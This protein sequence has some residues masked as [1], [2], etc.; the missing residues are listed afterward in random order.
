MTTSTTTPGVYLVQ[1]PGG[2]YKI[3]ESKCPADRL[4]TLDP[5]GFGFELLHAIPSTDRKGLESIL[6][7]AFA[8]RRVRGE[9]FRLAEEDVALIRSVPAAELLADLPAAVVALH[10]A[11]SPQQEDDTSTPR[12]ERPDP[13]RDIVVART[14]ELGLTAYAVAKACGIDPDTVR[15]YL[16]GR[17]SLNSR[18]LS[19]ILMSLGWDAELVWSDDENAPENS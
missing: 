16:T 14:K 12:T 7:T 2:L 8:H 15:R 13:M 19:A 11:N 5:S 4:A 10:R 6:H 1:A 9:W 18:Y 3:G 17:V